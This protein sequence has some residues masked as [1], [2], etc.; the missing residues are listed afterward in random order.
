VQVGKALG[1]HVIAVASTTEKRAA[2]QEAGADAVLDRE[3]EG[4]RDRLKALA[5]D[6]LDVVFDPVCGPLLQPAFRSLRWGGRHLVI[7]FAGGDIPALPVN[8]PLLKGAA[9]VG[10]DYRQY[11]EVFETEAAAKALGELLDWAGA[12]RLTPP[13]GRVFPFDEAGEGLA[14]ALTGQGIGKTLLAVGD[15][16]SA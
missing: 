7:G 11:A 1:A 13:V 12:G 6:G 15:G 4:W 10:V 5:P 16:G 3:P 9:L 8:L 2:A 14:F